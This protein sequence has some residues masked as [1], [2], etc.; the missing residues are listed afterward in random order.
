MSMQNM[1]GGKLNAEGAYQWPGAGPVSISTT[2]K[3][4]VGSWADWNFTGYEGVST[5]AGG[6]EQYRKSYPEYHDIVTTMGDLGETNG[7]GRAMWEHEEQ[8]DRYGTPMALMLLPFWTDGCIGSMEGLYFEAST[9]TP[10]HF[11]NQDELSYAPSN[12]QRDL[13]YDPGPPD[14]AEFDE[15][16]AHLQMT[17]VRYYMA[18]NDAT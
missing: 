3:G 12:A 9:T 8:H 1:P 17:G 6:T 15:G 7:C 13:P 4:F 16:V 2:D 18:I 14:Q 11:L 10:Y 5:L